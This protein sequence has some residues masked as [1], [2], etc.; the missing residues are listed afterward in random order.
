MDI[1]VIEGESVDCID[2]A[3]DRE[4]WRVSFNGIMNL[5]IADNNFFE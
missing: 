3:Q 2:L 5:P 1:T 4:N